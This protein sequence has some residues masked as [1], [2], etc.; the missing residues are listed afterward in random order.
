MPNAPRPEKEFL[1]FARLGLRAGFWAS[2]LE[3]MQDDARLL[4]MSFALL[5][6]E[7]FFLG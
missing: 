5:P 1:S 2:L 3:G 6:S 7:N 4:G